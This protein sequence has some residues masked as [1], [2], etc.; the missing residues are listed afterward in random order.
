MI[1]HRTHGRLVLVS[2][3][4]DDQRSDP[5]KMLDRGRKIHA[6]L[7]A[8]RRVG[9]EIEPP[10]ATLDRLRPPERGFQINICRIERHCRGIATHD[11]GQ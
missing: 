8:M 7:E 11:A 10:G 2:A 5:F 1:V 6:A 4:F 3:D 9:R